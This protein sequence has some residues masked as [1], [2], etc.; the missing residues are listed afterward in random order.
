[1]FIF[2]WVAVHATFRANRFLFLRVLS[3]LKFTVHE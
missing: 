1:M 3:E 2:P